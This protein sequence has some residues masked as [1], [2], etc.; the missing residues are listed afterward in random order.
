M[1]T[2]KNPALETAPV[3]AK[4]H[5]PESSAPPARKRKRLSKAFPRPLDKKLKK[6]SVVKDSFSF[7]AVEHEHLVMLKKRLLSEGVEVKKSE[8]VRAGLVLL[9]SLDA[10]DLKSLLAKVP[11]V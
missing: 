1:S 2:S 3:E 8:L 10:D 7:P 5:A 11:R 9:A 6:N 4:G